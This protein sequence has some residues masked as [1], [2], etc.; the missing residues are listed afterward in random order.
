MTDNLPVEFQQSGALVASAFQSM[1]ASGVDNDDL[2]GGVGGGFAS[3]SKRGSKFHL[4]YKG[5]E[6]PLNDTN[7]Y[8]MPFFDVV[9]VRANKHITKNYYPN[10]YK[11]GSNEAP[12]CFSLD[13]VK[14]APQVENP[15]HD[16]CAMCPM[17]AFGS[18]I[19]ENGKK[20]KACSD[21]RKIAFVPE[22]DMKNES[23]GGAMLLRISA[24][25]LSDLAT[26]ANAMKARGF[27]YYAVVTRLE[28]D[29]TVSHPKLKFKPL[30]PLT[31]D[32]ALTIIEHQ[33]SDQVQKILA[34]FDVG[35]YAAPV[36][37]ATVPAPA[38]VAAPQPASRVIPMPAPKAPPAAVAVPAPK[39]APAVATIVPPAPAATPAAA[40]KPRAAKPVPPAAPAPA[41]P[42]E[43]QSVEPQSLDDDIE[44]ILK[45][46]ASAG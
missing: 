40:R 27:P 36:A 14:P 13:G 45:D 22:W 17:N 38:P 23:F 3:L 15:I 26:Y 11:E 19:T 41:A 1:I 37:A 5:D 25:E 39:S 18:R 42:V 2:T 4:K 30:R 24:S 29:T 12:T 9:F 32:E 35:D 8:P 34:D 33:H 16:N 46:L 20:A 6:I 31:N 7:G 21:N 44:N 43:T 10:G 28:F